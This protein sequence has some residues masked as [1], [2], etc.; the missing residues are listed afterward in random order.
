MKLVLVT[1]IYLFFMHIAK[2]QSNLDVLDMRIHVTGG[3][4][5]IQ[6]TMDELSSNYKVVF[7]YEP[8]E[9]PL[10]K[11]VTLPTRE[12]SL[13]DLLS[14]LFKNAKVEFSARS[15][16][17]ILKKGASPAFNPKLKHTISG[18]IKDA[19]SGETL[20]GA[21][22]YEQD[23]KA[24]EI[25]N[26]YGFYALSLPDGRY[27][28]RI[29]SV[30]Y[31]TLVKDTTLS[32][33]IHYD[34]ELFPES[35]EL[36]E[37]VITQDES[38]L[39]KFQRGI[40]TVDMK[41][42]KELPSLF[43]ES[44]VLRNILLLPGV[45]SMAELGGDFQVRGGSWD[46]NLM[47]LD[48]APVYNSNHL[49]G[50]YSTFNPDII[51]DIKFYKAGIPANYGSRI[52]SVMDISQKDGNMKSF[53][54]T[55]GIGLIA[56]KLSVEGPLIKDKVSF[57]V[58]ARRST[59]E[60]FMKNINNEQASKVRP[61]FY[62]INAKLNYV[63]NRNNHIYL[64]SYMGQDVAEIEKNNQNYGNITS[65]LRYNHIF[66]EKLFS[67]T[68]LIYSKY[69][70]IADQNGENLSY[71]AKLGLQHY[72][73]KNEFIYSLSRHKLEFG[74]R[75][76]YYTFHPGEQETEGDSTKIAKV[77]LPNQYAIE[78]AVYLND[79]FKINANLELQVGVRLS[80]YNLIGPADVFIYQADVPRN[81]I[82]VIGSVH[83]K[84]NEVIQTY[85]NIE[86]RASLKYNITENQTVTLS[87][88]KMVQ[89][90]QLVSRTFNPLP[91]DM[92]K[93]SNNYIKPLWGH[94]YSVGWFLHLPEKSIDISI[95]SYYKSLQN[96]LEVKPGTEIQL[97]TTL[98]ASL[99]QGK[100]RAYGIETAAYKTKGRLTGMVSYTWSRT[101]KKIDG[102]FMEEK[103]N[104]G[105]YY[106]SDYDIPH[107]I[108]LAGEYKVSSRFYL[109]ANFIYQTGRPVTYP[110]GQ[111]TYF[112]IL[113]PYY[114]T[115][116]GDRYPALHRLDVGA[117]LHNKKKEGRKWEGFWTFS[118]YNVYARQNYY[119]AGIRKISGSQN[120]EA[121]KLWFFGIV[122][123]LSYSFKF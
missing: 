11:E 41:A 92:W 39:T 22:I 119:Y 110:V 87:Y 117:V 71:K 17:I 25:A 47:L 57:I 40:S 26:E 50:V 4:T 62:D 82:E 99:L 81:P 30:G 32:S 83:Y 36:Q 64:S 56:S 107:K 29:S 20:I 96:V 54:V 112:N 116:N 88:N 68:S 5:T 104:F 113:L 15:G 23:L 13:K 91:Y 120:T 65:T 103:I 75:M 108:T 21:T 44:D 59:F 28:L 74:L 101:E 48:E 85:S 43:G 7:S 90:V 98:D 122:P 53:H 18:I 89:Y 3:N 58:A 114:N 51:K 95:E 19:K 24:G 94:Q 31:K 60:P 102:K 14:I 37:V 106:P 73:F 118:I 35:Q 80:N 6:K 78:S 70:M 9:I 121:F 33:N 1:L 76:V 100:G 72:E 27:Q 34:V 42:I 16:V 46:Q 55:G 10:N 52:S 45:S 2:G 12:M 38:N 61:Y 69:N 77:V 8:S 111:Y 109:T 97:N 84:K 105:N 63:I 123:S 67:N 49:F 79:N 115:K 66:G 86:P 93:P